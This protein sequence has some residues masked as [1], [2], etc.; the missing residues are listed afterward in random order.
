MKKTILL[1]LLFLIISGVAQAMPQGIDRSPKADS[2]LD[3]LNFEVSSGT[4]AS[5]KNLTSN[6]QRFLIAKG[7]KHKGGG[8]PGKGHGGGHPGKGK[9]KGKGGPFAGSSLP[10]W[11]HDCGLPPGLAKQ[12]KV[13]PGW[14]KKCR[15]GYKY[16]DHEEEFREVV[17]GRQTGPIT[18]DSPAYRTIYEMDDAACKVKSITSVGDIAEGA[19]KGAV[20]GGAI[21]AVGGAIYGA[22]T[23]ADVADSAITGGAGGA[24]G[25][26]VLGGILAS[27]DYKNRYRRC[28]NNR[29]H[30]I[31]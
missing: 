21:G 13:P 5:I 28:M 7:P 10:S 23:D 19:V 22:V 11:A 9:H 20:Y 6:S 2:K 30:R 4:I 3:K 12:N 1:A 17:Y 8:H 14:E 27:N 31:N 15:A 24:A 26:A 25:G 29:G 16:Y 18:Q